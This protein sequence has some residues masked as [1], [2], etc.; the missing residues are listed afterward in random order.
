MWLSV[1]TIIILILA[2]FSINML[3]VVKVVSDSAVNAVKDKVDV[4]LYLDA[5]ASEKEIQS[6]SSKINNLS[7][8]EKVDYT[9]KNEALRSF[10]SKNQNNPEVSE[11]LRELGTNPLTPSLTI[12]PKQVSTF[13]ELTHELNKI[14]SEII[15]SRNFTDHERILQKINQVTD[16]V[17]NA[18]LVVSLIFI[19]ITL[20]VVY[21][22]IRV[23]IYTHEKEISIMRLVG[24]SN[25]FIYMPFLF[26]SIIYTFIGVLTVIAIFYPFL[27]ILQPYL[28][29][30]FA[31]YDMN[32]ITYFNSNFFYIFGLQFL[33][34][35]L[36]NI[37][38][39]LIAVR[40]YSQV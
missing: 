9:S 35:A 5:N 29:T 24:G 13:D 21:N 39:S 37:V 2:L 30:F 38:A 4:S 12:K 23:A 28:D 6:L 27:S 14:D 40:K 22:S 18:G 25:F 8:V 20:L 17:S 15:I 16:R 3:L 11:A 36:I 1:V 19:L 26:S 31:N 33:G 34:I 7:L 10:R 32:I